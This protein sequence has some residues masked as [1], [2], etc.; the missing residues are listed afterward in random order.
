MPTIWLLNTFN[1]KIDGARSIFCN[2]RIPLHLGQ[3]LSYTV[4]NFYELHPYKANN[5]T[6]PT[7]FSVR[8]PPFE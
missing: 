5:K 3:V 2:E 8:C 6:Y 7:L 4:S 1:I